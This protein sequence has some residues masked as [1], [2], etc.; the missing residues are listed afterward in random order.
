[1]FAKI[2]IL[3]QCASMAGLLLVIVGYCGLG[4]GIEI[5]ATLG[6]NEVEVRVMLGW[7]YNGMCLWMCLGTRQFYTDS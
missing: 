4:D 1:V 3:K 5:S 6:Q 7:I 2:N